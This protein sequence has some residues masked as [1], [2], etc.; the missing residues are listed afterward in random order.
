MIGQAIA[1]YGQGKTRTVAHVFARIDVVLLPF[2]QTSPET[3][4]PSR[5]SDA[6]GDVKFLPMINEVTPGLESSYYTR[7]TLFGPQEVLVEPLCGRI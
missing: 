1:S 6:L 5:G 2:R 4:A 3:S 7:R